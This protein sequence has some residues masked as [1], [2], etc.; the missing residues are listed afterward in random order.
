M[1]VDLRK[2]LVLKVKI[3]KGSGTI[4][5]L[6]RPAGADEDSGHARISQG[7]GKGHLCQ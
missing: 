7:P 1:L 6:F 4:L 3:G 5:D 2:L